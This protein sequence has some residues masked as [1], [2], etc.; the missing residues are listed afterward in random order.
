ML[1]FDLD[2]PLPPNPSSHVH[3]FVLCCGHR[4][5]QESCACTQYGTS[6][7]PANSF[8][9][10]SRRR[11]IISDIR[12]VCSA[13]YRRN[14]E[15]IRDLMLRR[16]KVFQRQAAVNRNKTRS[17]EEEAMMSTQPTP[18]PNSSSNNKRYHHHTT[19]PCRDS[20][21]EE[22]VEYSTETSE[23]LD[24]IS[25]YIDELE[26]YFDDLFRHSGVTL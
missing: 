4:E 21:D 13:C 6:A 7:L 15:R 24:D 2:F 20:D 9:I 8:I 25:D 1:K 10:P 23:L 19:K 14:E 22:R 11:V 17:C 18:T 26:S 16:R 12:S 5:R 3:V